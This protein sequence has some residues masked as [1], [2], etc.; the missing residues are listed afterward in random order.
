MFASHSHSRSPP[1]PEDAGLRSRSFPPE[2]RAV[3][4]R[5]SLSMAEALDDDHFGP[6]AWP[7]R[8]STAAAVLTFRMAL[9][10]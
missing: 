10:S 4:M 8:P 6:T 9:R 7:L 5:I 2:E 1:S 3:G